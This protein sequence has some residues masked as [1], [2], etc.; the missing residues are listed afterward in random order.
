MLDCLIIFQSNYY[1]AHWLSKHQMSN[2]TTEIEPL[3]A[4]PAISAKRVVAIVGRPNV[5]KSALFN[6]IA[7]Q[8]ISI[9]HDESGVTRDRIVRNVKWKD[10][11][12]DLVDTGGVSVVQGEESHE[13]IAAGVIAQVEAALQDAAVAILV[14]DVQTGLHPMDKEVADRIR[15]IGIPC[16][17]AVN[18]CD[19]AGHELAGGEFH[20]LGMPVYHVSALHNRG[21]YA[22]VND[23][24]SFL[25]TE[26][27]LQEGREKALRIAVVGRPNA[28]KSSYINRLLRH[29]RVIVSPIAGTTR[30][31]IEIPFRIGGKSGRDCILI[32]TAGMRRLG[33]IDNA[34]ERYSLLRAEQSI[35]DAD[36]VALIIDA[37]EGP[38]MQDKQIAARIQKERKGC[39]V[40]V[41]KWDLAMDADVTQTSYEPA[42]RAEMPFT[43]YCPVVFV[44]AESGY[45]V[46][47]SIDAI[48]LVAD[49][50]NRVIATG[51]LNRALAEALKQVQ[52]PG[53]GRRKLKIFYATQT[54][55][56]PTEIRLFV[57]DPKLVSDNFNSYL[58]RSLR[59]RFGFQGAPIVLRYRARSEETPVKGGGKIKR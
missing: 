44:S 42:L 59:E 49:E 22:L 45:N 58:I 18:K 1:P 2:P 19:I 12:F 56:A 34:V 30:D 55:V 47:R 14:V 36:I 24:R 33:R 46:R 28:G 27:F 48:S 11:D 52:I 51:P 23:A 37:S 31:S 29:P 32:D 9:V 6:R 39:V 16:L 50:I 20:A 57:N 35:R 10:S 40:I 7:R 21:I 4:A 3:K 43:N 17:V 54:G 26:E 38:T 53:S 8:R 13:E 5:G 15:R 41:N 25:P